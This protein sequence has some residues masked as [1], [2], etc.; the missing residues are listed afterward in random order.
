MCQTSGN[1]LQCTTGKQVIQQ[2][3]HG[4]YA[5]PSAAV[6]FSDHYVYANTHVWVML[7]H[8]K[9]ADDVTTGWFIT[10]GSSLFGL[11]SRFAAFR[12]G[13]YLSLQR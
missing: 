10:A 1:L 4:G 6:P 3:G 8:E 13:V 11:S 7:S 5:K 2:R 9:G 12:P